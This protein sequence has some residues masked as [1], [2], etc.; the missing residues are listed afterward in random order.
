MARDDT[1]DEKT[2]LLMPHIKESADGPSSPDDAK[3]EAQ[4]HKRKLRTIAF[5]FVALLF[6]RILVAIEIFELWG[7]S[8][9]FHSHD[10]VIS[11]ALKILKETPLIGTQRYNLLIYQKH[12]L[13]W[14]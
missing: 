13:M 7:R 4:H 5:A 11:Q 9:S 3:R 1:V 2:G 8:S 10:R 12:I 6:L 14:S